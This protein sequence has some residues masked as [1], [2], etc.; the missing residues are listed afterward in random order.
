MRKFLK[1]LFNMSLLQQLS[2]IIVLFV[3]IFILF[4]TVYLRGNID[5]FVTNQCMDIIQRSQETI[6]TNLE[7]GK[8]GISE[9]SYDSD[10]MHFVFVRGKMDT[11][12]GRTTYTDAFL[13]QITE[14]V[15]S[16]ESGWIESKTKI[17]NT[18][19]YYRLTT[20]NSRTK[21]I[22]LMDES[23]GKNIGSSLLSSVSN[24]TAIIFSALFILL[25]LWVISII[26][27][28]HQIRTYIEK[29]QKGDETASLNVDRGDE[30]GDMA[31]ALVEMK[32][33]IDDQEKTK[34]EMIHNISHDL[35]TPI[36]II[37]SYGE[38]IRDGVYP[39][40]TLDKSVDVIVENADRLSKKVQSLLFLNRLDFVM[41]QEKDTNKTTDMVS[42]VISVAQSFK[43]IR[44]EVK[45]EKYLQKG[46]VFRGDEE[47]W[48]IV[49]SNLL[50]N[51]LRYAEKEVVIDVHDETLTVFNDGQPIT[52]E[53]QKRLF[54]P[55]ER[56]DKGKFG[57]GLSI[58]YKVCNIYGYK[59]EQ[60]N[61]PNGV[62]FI[63]SSKEV[64]EEKKS[65][66][67]LANKKKQ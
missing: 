28:L 17:E 31:K 4:F 14:M 10:V 66:K 65:K 40:D 54:K 21:I 57:L 41:D 19:Y 32:N 16:H 24:N 49:L 7:S 30:I 29:V 2:A 58:C 45:V 42:L 13:E 33:E 12:Y 3:G 20:V 60:E 46:V 27:P 37:K 11:Y 39:Y 59:I 8:Q 48:R 1:S 18:M 56:G 43:M 38:S 34:E 15:N 53:Q 25:L 26:N 47:S 50:D 55:F 6:T 35:K 44:P 52:E 22:S 51:A 62:I 64:P 67:P 61:M 36:A 5:D 9:L 63:I 23:Y